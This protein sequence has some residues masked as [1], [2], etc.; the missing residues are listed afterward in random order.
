MPKTVGGSN[1]TY[2]CDKINYYTGVRT[3]RAGGVF[4][5]LNACGIFSVSFSDF[6]TDSPNACCARSILIFNNGGV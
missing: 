2:T 6:P 3:M 4:S 1:F 5:Q